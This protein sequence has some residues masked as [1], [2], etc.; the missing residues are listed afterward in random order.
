MDTNLRDTG[1]TLGRPATFEP[2]GQEP[3]VL[4]WLGPTERE[5]GAAFVEKQPDAWKP[6]RS[7]DDRR[8]RTPDS[9]LS[10]RESQGGE[11]ILRTPL[12]RAVFITGLAGAVV[13]ALFLAFARFAH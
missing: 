11:I 7:S 6:S 12:R 2:A 13:L 10:G 4:L 5:S 8:E 9:A 1:S 3:F